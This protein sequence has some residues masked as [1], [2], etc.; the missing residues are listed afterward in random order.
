MT[1]RRSMPPAAA[2]PSSPPRSGA[3]AVAVGV[4]AARH[5]RCRHD[6]H[7]RRCV[8]NPRGRAGDGCGDA[9]HRRDVVGPLPA[10]RR[11]PPAC[12]AHGRGAPAPPMRGGVGRRLGRA[13][14]RRLMRPPRGWRPGVVTSVF[15]PCPHLARPP[16][17]GRGGDGDAVS[18]VPVSG[19]RPHRPFA[20][21]P[22]GRRTARA[23][24][25]PG[26]CPCRRRARARAGAA[27]GSR[28]RCVA[29]SVYR[30]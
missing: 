13:G 3:G 1:P 19:H 16:P 17:C 11:Q 20:S 2:P 14:V 4:V 27:R 5:W 15:L 26:P 29:P 18:R 7:P 9:G 6:R 30:S 12:A 28:M 23:A 21:G 10:F 8:H 24:A 25:R 22:G